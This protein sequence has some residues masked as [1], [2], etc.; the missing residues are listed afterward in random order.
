MSTKDQRFD[1]Q[2]LAL[3]AAGCIRIFADKKSGKDAEREELTKVLDYLRPGDT[4]VVPSLDRLARSL[5]GLVTIVAELRR[6]G[7]G[8]R[9]LKEALDTTTPGGRLVFRCSPPWP[10][11]S[12]NSPSRAPTRA[13]PPPRP[14]VFGSADRPR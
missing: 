8:F 5:Q 4:L 7:V 12:A 2:T 13:W 9:F 3:K 6:R 10:S 1:R 14:A 11:L